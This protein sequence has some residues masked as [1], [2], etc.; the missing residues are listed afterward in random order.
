MPPTP[1]SMLRT[2]RS[3]PGTSTKPMRMV[4]AVGG[5]EFEVSKTDIDRNAAPL[6]FFEAVGINAGQRFDERG[7]SVIDMS[8]GADDDGLHLR[9]YRRMRGGHSVR[10][11]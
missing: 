4:L 6:F 3:W 11:L 8:G 7:F 1:A 2:K 10:R 5:G 9:Q